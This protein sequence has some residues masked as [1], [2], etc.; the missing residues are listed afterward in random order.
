V[1]SCHLLLHKLHVLVV[2]GIITENAYRRR[3]MRKYEG[4]DDDSC[5]RTVSVL[6][7]NRFFVILMI[8]VYW[9]YIYAVS[10]VGFLV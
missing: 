9:R 6:L 2:T 5:N 10:H 4:L 1:F 3:L 8:K 7:I